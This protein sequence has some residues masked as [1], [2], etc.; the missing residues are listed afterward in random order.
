MAKIKTFTLS[1]SKKISV[2]Y[3]SYSSAIT[4]SVELEDNDDVD[5]VKRQLSDK[6]D[7]GIN[8]EIIKM[9]KNDKIGG[10]NE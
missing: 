6:I 9:I 2:N 8:S 4:I 5:E 3:N 1:N 10:N 7:K